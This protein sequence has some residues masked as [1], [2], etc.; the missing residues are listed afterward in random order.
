MRT[1]RHVVVDDKKVAVSKIG[2][3]YKI[4]FQENGGATLWKQVCLSRLKNAL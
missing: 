3:Y 1:S 4:E 2:N